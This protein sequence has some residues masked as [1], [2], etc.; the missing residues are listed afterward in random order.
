MDLDQF[1]KVLFSSS[2]SERPLLQSRGFEGAA[3]HWMTTSS[4]QED[5]LYLVAFASAAGAQSYVL[6]QTEAHEDDPTHASDTKF[7]VPGLTDGVGFENAKLDSYG[8]ADS[9]VLGSL[10]NV[11]VIVDSYTPANLARAEVLRLVGQQVARLSVAEKA[12]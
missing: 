10:G 2:P 3:S 4:G 9:W 7:S 11:A 5:C 8:N 1:M 12:V 6:G